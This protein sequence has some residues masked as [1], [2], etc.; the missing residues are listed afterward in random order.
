MSQPKRH[1]LMEC[2]RPRAQQRPNQRAAWN[3][4]SLLTAAACYARGTHS[5]ELIQPKLTKGNLYADYAVPVGSL[6]S[7]DSDTFGCTTVRPQGARCRNVVHF[8]RRS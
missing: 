2:A 1:G 4:L 3:T 8:A 7:K 5:A 6:R